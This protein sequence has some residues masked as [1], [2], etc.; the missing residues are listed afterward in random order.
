[1]HLS[2]NIASPF[3]S[4]SCESGTLNET[5][6][7]GKIVLCFDTSEHYDGSE[8]VSASNTVRK[9]GGVGVI[10][11]QSRD[12]GFRFCDAIPCVKVDYEAGTHILSYIRR[13][14]SP[15]AK[16]SSASSVVGKLVSPR[17]ASFSSRGPS[18]MS[19][20]VLKVT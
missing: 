10:F 15:V 4:R 19:P 1:M 7:T 13:A 16:L 11:A 8:I 20:Q 18:S 14:K 9:A 3:R 17:I 12:D 6:T 5:L 2:I